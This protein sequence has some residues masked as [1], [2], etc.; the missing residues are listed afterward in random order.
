MIE[1]ITEPITAREF[2]QIAS[3]WESRELV[4]FCNT[5]IACYAE[6][7]KSEIQLTEQIYLPDG[8]IDAELVVKETNLEESTFG[9]VGPGR[10]VYQ[11]KQ[12][13]VIR[14]VKSSII[15]NLKVTEEARKLVRSQ[16]VPDR[17]VLLTNVQLDHAKEKLQKN[18]TSHLT[19]AKNGK[20]L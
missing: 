3:S 17:Y 9:L 7:L 18:I 13:N 5:L 16:N 1:R 14:P 4:R 6:G 2:E 20:I 12:R 10:T 8:G 19:P 11:F 15:N